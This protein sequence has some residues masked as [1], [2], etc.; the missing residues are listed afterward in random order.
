MELG[1]IPISTLSLTVAII[2]IVLQM[3]CNNDQEE[4]IDELIDK[5][6]VQQTQIQKMGA[7]VESLINQ[8]KQTE[9]GIVTQR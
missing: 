2:S 3:G 7:N 4:R 8:I 6:L 9:N 5:I 1:H